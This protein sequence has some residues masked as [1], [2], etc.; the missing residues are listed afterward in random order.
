MIF[1]PSR[2]DRYKSDLCTLKYSHHFSV[3]DMR[4]ATFRLELRNWA[5][6]VT[7]KIFGDTDHADTDSDT[8][9]TISKSKYPRNCH[10]WRPVSVT[11]GLSCLSLRQHFGLACLACIEIWWNWNCSCCCLCLLA[12]LR[13]DTHV[14]W[15]WPVMWAELS[16]A[17]RP[18]CKA[19]AC[20]NATAAVWGVYCSRGRCESG[21]VLA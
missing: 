19:F 12:I 15:A 16:W 9:K 18:V 6:V 11:F 20:R 2:S 7:P 21:N 17:S 14:A 5:G 3:R 4:E 13:L 10:E 8:G 1:D